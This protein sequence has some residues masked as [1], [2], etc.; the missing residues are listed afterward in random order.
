MAKRKNKPIDVILFRHGIIWWLL[1][2]WWW[3]PTVYIFWM[4]FNIIF[5][6]EIRF[7]KERKK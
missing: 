3:R 4:F 1:I 2:G 6:T 5:N 7:K